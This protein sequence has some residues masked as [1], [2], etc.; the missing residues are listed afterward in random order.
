MACIAQGWNDNH[1]WN[2]GMETQKW[3]L[4]CKWKEWMDLHLMG[5]IIEM[6]ISTTTFML[7]KSLFTI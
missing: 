1:G 6:N 7:L 2:W 5:I 4:G 3:K